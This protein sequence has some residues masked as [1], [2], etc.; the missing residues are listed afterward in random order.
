MT[1]FHAIAP[2]TPL[3]PTTA[4]SGTNIV[5][6]WTAPSNNGADITSY[7]IQILQSDGSLSEELTDCNGSDSS[8]VLATECTI[9]LATLTASPYSLVTDN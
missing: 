6:N 5:I 9:P 8:I 3:A 7:Q 4:N 2:D 1:V